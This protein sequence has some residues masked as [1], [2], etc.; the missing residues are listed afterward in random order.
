[1]LKG[2]FQSKLLKI[3]VQRDI[4]SNVAFPKSLVMHIL[5]SE[6][7]VCVIWAFLVSLRVVF[8]SSTVEEN[9]ML[10]NEHVL[11]PET[12]LSTTDFMKFYFDLSEM[13]GEMYVG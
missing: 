13:K 4:L 6:A 1:M 3:S 9:W 7:F 2:I 8:A 12:T 10:N 5:S 11:P